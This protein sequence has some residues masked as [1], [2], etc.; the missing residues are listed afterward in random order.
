MTVIEVVA[1]TVVLPHSIPSE[2]GTET[3]MMV[4]AHWRLHQA[5]SPN[6]QFHEIWRYGTFTLNQHIE[7]WWRHISG[8]Q[9]LAWKVKYIF[10]FM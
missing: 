10:N 1:S 7:A 6:I 4:S 5:T 8:S 9:T 2:R 3:M